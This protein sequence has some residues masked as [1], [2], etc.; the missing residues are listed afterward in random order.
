M[1]FTL[2]PSLSVRHVGLTRHLFMIPLVRS[3]RFNQQA[4]I[5]R[6][7]ALIIIGLSLNTRPADVRARSYCA[8]VRFPAR[9]SKCFCNRKK[10]VLP[11]VELFQVFMCIYVL[12]IHVNYNR[13]QSRRMKTQKVC[14]YEQKL[15][16]IDPMINF[17]S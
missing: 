16:D 7:Y 4:C 5:P 2:G 3:L 13:Q 11:L 12:V 8:N 6:R 9:S 17:R 15:E 14:V 10:N 1:C